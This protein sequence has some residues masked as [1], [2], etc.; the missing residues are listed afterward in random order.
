MARKSPTLFEIGLRAKT[1]FSCLLGSGTVMCGNPLTIVMSSMVEFEPGPVR[2]EM[3][4]V[5]FDVVGEGGEVEQDALERRK[6]VGWAFN[7]AAL[8]VL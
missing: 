1:H 4:G 6:S 3:N 8:S 2:A 5:V 7:I